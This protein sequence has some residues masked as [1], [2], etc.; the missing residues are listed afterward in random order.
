MK[1]WKE[2]GFSGLKKFFDK[3]GP[4]WMN[5]RYDQVYGKFI[6]SNEDCNLNTLVKEGE[7][8]HNDEQVDLEGL[9][10]SY[11]KFYL[12]SF[13]LGVIKLTVERI[14]GKYGQL[15]RT[16]LAHAAELPKTPTHLIIRHGHLTRFSWWSDFVAHYLTP[17]QQKEITA[18]RAKYRK[19]HSKKSK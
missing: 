7:I 2:L 17:A 5:N 12:Y 18:A 11:E 14:D 3:V 10:S 1:S 6:A 13:E 9:I 19:E 8:Y 15:P 4:A 16:I